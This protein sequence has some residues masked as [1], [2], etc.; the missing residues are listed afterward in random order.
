M[1]DQR[2]VV[3]I[4][5]DSLRADHGGPWG[6]ERDTTPNLNA[7]ADDGVVFENAIAPASRANPTMTGTFTG[8]PLVVRDQVADPDPARRHLSRHDTL[9]EELSEAGYATG[10]FCPNVYASRYYGFDRGF[11]TYEDFM[12]DNSLYQDLFDK[13]V[14]GSGLLTAIRN[15]R[16]FVF[17]Q[18]AFKTGTRTSRGWRSGLVTSPSCSSSGRSRWTRTSRISR[19]AS[20]ASGAACSTSATTIGAPTSSSTSTT[21]PWGQ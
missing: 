2:N 18:E 8:E 16:N 13:H 14:S 6:Y 7:M 9:A 10:A 20:T 15:A 5:Y 4:T 21:T 17:R 11:D 3:L 19:R 12:F 1:T